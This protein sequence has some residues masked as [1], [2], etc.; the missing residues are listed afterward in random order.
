MLINYSCIKYF[1]ILSNIS[2]EDKLK[3][4]DSFINN[5]MNI[6]VLEIN[7][8]N[9]CLN[10]L[11]KNNMI[12]E[13]IVILYSDIIDEKIFYNTFDKIKNIMLINILNISCKLFNNSYDMYVYKYF[14]SD[15]L[16]KLFIHIIH[17]YKMK[18]INNILNNIKNKLYTFYQS[19]ELYN[20]LNTKLSDDIYKL[21]KNNIL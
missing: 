10:K 4:D 14:S 1:D 19:I 18:N 20:T 11:Y 13:N 5:E 12:K 15:L 6:F 17:F 16:L 7:K 21:S 9:I 3:I 2:F 8:I